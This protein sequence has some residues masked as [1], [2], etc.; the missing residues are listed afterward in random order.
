ML[1]IFNV[2]TAKKGFTPL[3]IGGAKSKHQESK[4]LTG[5]TLIEIIVTISIFSIVVGIILGT[6]ISGVRQQRIFFA[7]QTILDQ[8]SYALEYIGRALRMAR[9]ELSAPT[10]LSQNGLNYEVKYG[11]S[12]LRFI[13]FLEGG[14]CQEI[15][16]QNGHLKYQKDLDSAMPPAP[17]NLTSDNLEIA[18]IH[19]S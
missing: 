1:K 18:V 14:D 8:T 17:L 9:K 2:K 12:G 15:Y 3:E 13:N 7:G 10:C 5:F 4:S 11:G 16:L 19:C 6:F